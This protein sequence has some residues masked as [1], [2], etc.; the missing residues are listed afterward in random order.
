MNCNNKWQDLQ[1]SLKTILGQ[2]CSLNE[3]SKVTIVNFSSEVKF[4]YID[5]YPNSINVGALTF[6]SG[7]TNFE[8]AF[9]KALKHI[10]TIRTGDVVLIF[11]TDGE[12]A[13]PTNAIRDLK[14]YL[15]DYVFTNLNIRFSFDAIGFQCG[16]EILKTL[17]GEIGGTSHFAESETQLTQVYIEI[18]NR[19]N[20]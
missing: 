10:K 4:E 2:V 3:K 8:A 14:A 9:A 19:E 11:M 16:S 17:V 6:Q 5:E 12:S 13:Y 7:G 1:K 20:A 15:C 18:L